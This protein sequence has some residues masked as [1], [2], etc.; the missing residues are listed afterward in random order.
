[1]E[2][3]TVGIYK[4]R[5]TGKKRERERSKI[6]RGWER[7]RY[8]KTRG[9]APCSSGWAHTWYVTTD[10]SHDHSFVEIGLAVR[11]LGRNTNT[12]CG[13]AD[14]ICVQSSCRLHEMTKCG[15]FRTHPF[16]ELSNSTD[17]TLYGHIYFSVYFVK[18]TSYGKVVTGTLPCS[19]EPGT[20]PHPEVIS[21]LIY[22]PCWCYPC[23]SP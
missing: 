7:W 3:W 21:P 5:K 23:I 10:W 6:E 16:L 12:D 8:K 17:I 22:N 2:W 13:H 15:T 20:V 4:G 19:Q 9:A 18:C 14:C 11:N 1:V